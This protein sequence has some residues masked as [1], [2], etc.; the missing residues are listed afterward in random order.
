MSNCSICGDRMDTKPATIIVG[1]EIQLIHP[2]C[3][4]Y[5]IKLIKTEN[6]RRNEEVS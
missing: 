2:E 1:G 3:Q 6:D 5:A 4:K